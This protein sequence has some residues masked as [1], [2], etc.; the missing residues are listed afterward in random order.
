MSASFLV[1]TAAGLLCLGVA[2]G[3]LILIALTIL[4]RK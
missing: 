2:G 4:R 3:L 1:I